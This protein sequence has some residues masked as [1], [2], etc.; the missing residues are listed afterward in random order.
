MI[1]QM[2]NL[3]MAKIIIAHKINKETSLQHLLQFIIPYIGKLC[4][5]R[6]T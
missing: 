3:L 1:V 5:L 2:C 6:L 4:R